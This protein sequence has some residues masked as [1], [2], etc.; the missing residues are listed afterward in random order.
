MAD[1]G[2]NPAG[3]RHDRVV[4]GSATVTGLKFG[5]VVVKDTATTNDR[6][7]VKSTTTACDKPVAG[8]IVSQTDPTNGSAVGDVLE[9]CDQG[10]V[11]AW[12]VT[13]SSGVKGDKLITSTTA[14]Q[15]KKLAAETGGDVVGRANMDWN[16]SAGAILISLTLTPG[17]AV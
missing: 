8:V 2:L 3:V 1:Y 17:A 7:A 13:G 5:H 6:K 16:A 11:E 14:G 4:G 10:I 12:V 9:I 15:L